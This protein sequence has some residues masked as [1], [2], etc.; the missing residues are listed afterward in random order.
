MITEIFSSLKSLSTLQPAWDQLLRESAFHTPFQTFAW[1]SAIARNFE[2]P[3]DLFIVAIYDDKSLIGLAPLCRSR[4]RDGRRL[5]R[6]LETSDGPC[7]YQGCI[8]RSGREE[9]FYRA[10]MAALLENKSEWDEI[11]LTQIPDTLQD[12]TFL[13]DQIQSA[14][15][16]FQILQENNSFRIHLPDN[17][18][19]VFDQI[20]TGISRNIGKHRQK[21]CQNAGY[22]TGRSGSHR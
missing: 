21:N 7:D 6:F 4:G 18:G 11:S 22:S 19:G 5:L 2:T 1:Q 16:L 10:L 9:D 20:V 14:G 12:I 13:L 17:L 3:E 15:L 8:I